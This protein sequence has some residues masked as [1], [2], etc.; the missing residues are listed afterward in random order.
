MMKCCCV[1]Y[2]GHNDV[3]GMEAEWFANASCDR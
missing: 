2:S 1:S 3:R